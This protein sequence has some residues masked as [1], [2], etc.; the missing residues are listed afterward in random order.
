MTHMPGP[1]WWGAGLLVA[2]GIVGLTICGMPPPASTA[3]AADIACDVTPY[4]AAGLDDEF[5]TTW[6]GSGDLW[7]GLDP[8]FAGVWYADSSGIKV[9]W[10]LPIGAPLSIAGE[11][12]DAPGP[13][14]R[15][16]IP[17]GYGASF[18]PTGLTFPPPG[19]WQVTG[20]VPGEQLQFIVLVQPGDANPANARS[21]RDSKALETAWDALRQRPVELTPVAPGTACPRSAQRS[22]ERV[23]G[24]AIGDGPV[25]L[26]G[27][28]AD[29]VLHVAEVPLAGN[30]AVV[31]ARWIATP[32]YAGPLLIRGQRLDASG[33]LRFGTG[34]AQA[35]LAFPAASAVQGPDWRVWGGYRPFLVGAPGCYAVQ[36]DGTDFSEVIVFEVTLTSSP[37]ADAMPRP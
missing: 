27:L 19:C 4:T 3:V 7:A 30:D 37:D 34:N 24:M 13:P 8:A 33:E 9:Q 17:H 22:V 36:V 1:R 11:R 6:Y 35:E 20:Q 12:L 18:Q 2:F 5:T 14:L 32:A 15:V 29:G 16:K 10:R 26:Q 21:A 31:P 25:A 23:E 28:D